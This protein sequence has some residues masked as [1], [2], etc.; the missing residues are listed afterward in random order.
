VHGIDLAQGPAIERLC[1]RQVDKV[2]DLHGQDSR[3]NGRAKRSVP[4]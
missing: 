2:N 3:S 1:E 4:A